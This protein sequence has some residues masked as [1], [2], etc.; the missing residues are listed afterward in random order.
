MAE[1]C[2]LSSVA[3][4]LP[5]CP[6]AY[7]GRTFV[8]RPVPRSLPFPKKHSVRLARPCECITHLRSVSLRSVGSFPGK[9]KTFPFDSF[10]RV[11]LDRPLARLAVDRQRF[12]RPALQP[13]ALPIEH[14]V[15][16]PIGTRD[17]AMSA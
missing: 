12:R 2:T 8:R 15:V 17:V 10:T 3:V 16:P 11:N 14:H 13:F 9:R 4:G 1:S 7:S 6:A 5:I